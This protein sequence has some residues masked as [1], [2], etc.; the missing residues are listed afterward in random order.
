MKTRSERKLPQTFYFELCALCRFLVRGLAMAAAELRKAF[1]QLLDAVRQAVETMEQGPAHV[2]QPIAGCHPLFSVEDFASRMKL[3]EKWQEGEAYPEYKGTAHSI[4]A[5]TMGDAIPGAP[6]SLHE[7]RSYQ[8][9]HFAKLK[10]SDA[11]RWKHPV[12]VVVVEGDASSYDPEAPAFRKISMDV[13]VFA[14]LLEL[15]KRMRLVETG[16]IPTGFL[17]AALHVPVNYVL[18]PA[19]AAHEENVYVLSLQIMEDFRTAEEEHAPRAWQLC[20]MWAQARDMKQ[21]AGAASEDPAAAVT[22]MLKR[23]RCSKNCEYADKGVIMKR[24][25]QDALNV[26]D[27]VLAADAGDALSYAGAEFGPRSPLTSMSKLVKLS[28]AVQGAASARKTHPSS[29]LRQTIQVMLLRLHL[30]LTDLHE[31]IAALGKTEIPRCIL[32]SELLTEAVSR[33]P[34]RGQP[35]AVEDII[36]SL[37]TSL[38]NPSAVQAAAQ[39]AIDPSAKAGLNW[40]LKVLMGQLDGVLR[41]MVHQDIKKSSA[42]QLLLHGKLNWADDVQLKLDSEAEAQKRHAVAT[43]A[44]SRGMPEEDQEEFADAVLALALAETAPSM[45]ALTGDVEQP[46]AAEAAA[47]ASP[48]ALQTTSPAE[49][50]V[51][52]AKVALEKLLHVDVGPELGAGVG[53]WQALLGKISAGCTGVSRD[54]FQLHAWVLDAASD[55]EPALKEEESVF[56][57]PPPVNKVLAERFFKAA[58][59]CTELEKQFMLLAPARGEGA[60]T[61]LTKIMT[62]EPFEEAVADHLNILY[63]ETSKGRGQRRSRTQ[64]LERVLGF[65]SKAAVAAAAAAPLKKCNRLHCTATSTM[66][67]SIINAPPPAGEHQPRLTLER[68][69]RVLSPGGLLRGEDL[70]NKAAQECIL[71]HHEKAPELW[72]EVFHHY[73]V[74]SI[75]TATPGSGAMLKGAIG[76]QI[77]AAALCKNAEHKAFLLEELLEWAVH[78]SRR[79]L[80]WCFV[81]DTDLGVQPAEAGPSDSSEHSGDPEEEEEEAEEASAEE[82]EESAPGE[83]ETP[84]ARKAKIRSAFKAAAALLKTRAADAKANAKAEAKTKAKGKE[85]EAASRNT[86]GDEDAKRPG[87]AL[88]PM[89]ELRARRIGTKR[90]L[91]S[92]RKISSSKPRASPPRSWAASRLPWQSS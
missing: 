73:R 43:A 89:Q 60:A 77:P 11:V 87:A 88:Q 63:K 34:S 78:E 54:G 4:F 27:R 8:E 36:L 50:R 76:L 41:E 23:V 33:L 10:P 40:V 62:E 59:R 38:P 68:K 57:R 74:S 58:G 12:S 69:A 9:T 42:K 75:A 32:I 3:P 84:A 28:Q 91:A 15:Q 72:A 70:E 13:M 17:Q 29:L 56:A 55:A 67:D 48:E 53:D 7:V 92:R 64:L 18:V 35:Q 31:G 39:E 51:A 66:S 61:M 46:R 6:V 19:S 82:A 45:P 49:A 24:V 81:T 14:F 86:G 22:E 2:M 83:E 71:L 25:V 20:Q 79:P 26:Y 5:L 52:F 65:A 47:A 44:A 37:A 30:S 21:K 85:G 1:P 16:C 90:R 80:S